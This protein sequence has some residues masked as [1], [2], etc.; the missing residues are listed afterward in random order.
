MAV[1][2]VLA[3]GEK[4][5]LLEDKSL[6]VNEAFIPIGQRHMIEYVIDAIKASEFIDKIVISG[7][8]D[9]LQEIY[10]GHQE[11][12]FVQQ[13]ETTIQSLLNA[14]DV[15]P[16]FEE[17]ILIVTGDVPLLTTQAVN[18]F[19]CSC[20]KRE[21]D[22]FYPIVS[23]E[24]NERK[25]PGIERTYVNLREGLFTGGNIMLL[26]PRIIEKCAP[27]AEDL[28]SL[29][30]KPISLACYIGWGIL[31]RYLLGRLSLKDAEE[32]VSNM[33]GIKGVGIISSYPEIGIDVDKLSDLEY[34]KKALCS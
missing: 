3:G 17:K 18:D 29:R 33:L 8:L 25:Y 32:R 15:L 12:T 4:K 19:I 24:N 5:G 28:V 14:L 13:G 9:K 31:F 26:N 16:S 21:E 30:K 20:L 1:A 6:A 27:I 7:P 2:V 34:V 10:G 11:L 22:L 23:R